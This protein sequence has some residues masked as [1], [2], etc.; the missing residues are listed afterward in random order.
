M[1]P[2]QNSSLYHGS[3]ERFKPERLGIQWFVSKQSVVDRL[4]RNLV[5]VDWKE[6]I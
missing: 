4:V 2:V 3:A 6:C 5:V 1:L